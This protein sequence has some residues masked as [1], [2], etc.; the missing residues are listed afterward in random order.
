MNTPFDPPRKPLHLLI[1]RRLGCVAPAV[2]T[3][4][5]LGCATMFSGTTQTVTVVTQPPGKSVY[6]NGVEIKDGERVTIQKRFQTPQFNIGGSRRPILVDMTYNPDPLIIG[7]GVLLIFWLVPGLI[8]GGVDAGTGAWRQLDDQQIVYISDAV[9]ASVI[10]SLKTDDEATPAPPAA[11]PTP[12][13]TPAAGPTPSPTPTPD[14]P[15]GP[16]EH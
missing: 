8:A 10:S 12:K 16:P 11:E 15:P 7:D 3:L 1:L 13:A 2:L 5:L 6:Y 9:S 4:P 14:G